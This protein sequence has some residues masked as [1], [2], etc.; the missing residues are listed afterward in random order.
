MSTKSLAL[1][2][3]R[4]G[5]MELRQVFQDERLRPGEL[6]VQVEYSSV[7]PLD[8]EMFNCSGMF[9]DLQLPHV[10]GVEGVGVVLKSASDHV[11]EGAR[12]AFLLRKFFNDDRHGTWQKRLVL[13]EKRAMIL[14]VPPVV[15]LNQI[16][17]CTTSTV[18][19]LAF[20]KP[21][22]PQSQIIVSGA[23]GAVGLAAMQLGALMG[24]KM[25]AFVRGPER[26]SWL[27]KELA[28]CGK[29]AV[30]D[31][32]AEEWVRLA[33]LLCSG[34]SVAV[35]DHLEEA[36]HVCGGAD[37]MVDGL[38]GEVLTLSA[39]YLLRVRATLVRFGG[40]ELPS[41]E[42]PVQRL[43]LKVLRESVESFMTTSDAKERVEA[44][45]A[46]IGDARYR[47]KAWHV[48]SWSEAAECMKDQPTWTR[49]ATQVKP[50]RIGRIILKFD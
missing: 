16:A 3:V 4:P 5:T 10:M 13:D 20:L 36:E 47:P 30:V 17:A 9:A 21:F 43:R 44:A 41:L 23:C 45:F 1:T 31:T 25:V 28:D 24:H 22:A 49:F 15:G 26:A 7:Q 29:V 2:L 50:G 27:A 38:G 34:E 6:L 19:A 11:P 14:Q 40:E 37:G 33:S 18:A 48:A 35:G 46:W 32:A 8:G 39:Q 12:I 42:E